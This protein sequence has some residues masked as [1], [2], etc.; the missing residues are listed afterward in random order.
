MVR[1]A[2]K[3]VLIRSM[4]VLS[5]PL[6]IWIPLAAAP[7]CYSHHYRP[8]RLCRPL[9][10]TILALSQPYPGRCGLTPPRFDDIYMPDLSLV[11]LSWNRQRI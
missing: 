5:I 7:P 2:A 11:R 6:V 10:T 3:D 8:R 1:S 9:P 4:T